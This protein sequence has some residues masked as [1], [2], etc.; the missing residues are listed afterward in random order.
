MIGT[1]EDLFSRRKIEEEKERERQ[2]RN[3]RKAGG[4]D[5]TESERAIAFLSQ[6]LLLVLP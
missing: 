2:G 3:R 1:V 4:R 5:L 6:A